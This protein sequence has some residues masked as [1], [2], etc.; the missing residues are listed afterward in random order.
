LIGASQGVV[1]LQTKVYCQFSKKP[2]KR[3][4]NQGGYKY[5]GQDD[6]QRLGHSAKTAVFDQG[7]TAMGTGS[8]FMAD[9]L[10]TGF[11]VL[12]VW[13]CHQEG[14]HLY[15]SQPCQILCGVQILLLM[16]VRPSPRK[17]EILRRYS[18]SGSQPGFIRHEKAT[19]R[20]AFCFW[21][22]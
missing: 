21:R 7:F 9:E 12:E 15:F 14:R 10:V 16:R 22:A 8:G 11:A 13:I 4:T 20:V 2:A 18:E 1:G 17:L 3:R 5:D 6:Y 19:A